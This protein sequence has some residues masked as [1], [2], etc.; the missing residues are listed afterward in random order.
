MNGNVNTLRRSGSMLL[1]HSQLTMGF[2]QLFLHK[3]KEILTGRDRGI[4]WTRDGFL[5]QS[6]QSVWE[7]EELHSIKV[8]SGQHMQ[9]V[10]CAGTICL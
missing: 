9:Y 2:E 5:S 6:P 8:S 4:E 10:I 7:G 3:E 1:I